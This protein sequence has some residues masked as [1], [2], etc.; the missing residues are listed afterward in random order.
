MTR[1]SQIHFALL[2]EP[3][4]LV[5][6]LLFCTAKRGRVIES[7][8]IS[9]QS[10]EARQN[11]NIW[12]SGEERLSRTS[13]LY[14]GESGVVVAHY[15]MVPFD[16]KHSG[17]AAGTHRLEVFAKLVDESKSRLLWSETLQITQEQAV[18][19]KDGPC[20]IYFDWGQETNRY[21]S[22][23]AKMGPKD[24]YEKPFELLRLMKD[25]MTLSKEQ[26][27][28]EDLNEGAIDA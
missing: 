7:M 2:P 25:V 13:G 3:Q 1:P 18:A 19:L 28:S 20:G 15:F 21:M 24:S 14:V 9:L 6:T 17:F 8:H 22:H 23:V 27:P 26:G 10:G 12:V 4:I 16:Q 11:F 5:R